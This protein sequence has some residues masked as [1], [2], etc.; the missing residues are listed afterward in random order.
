MIEFASAAP[1]TRFVGYEKLRAE[2]S[3]ARGRA[4]T[5]AR[6]LVK[7]EESPFYAEGG[8]QVADSGVVA[9]RRRRAR[10]RRRLPGRG[11]PGDPELDGRP[12]AGAGSRVEAGW[13][14]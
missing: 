8:G 4:R 1:P 7:L 3:R 5:T 11:R 14:T 10:R 13:T 9:L 6:A 2:T 12:T